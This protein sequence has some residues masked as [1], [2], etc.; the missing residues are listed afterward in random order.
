MKGAL[1]LLEFLNVSEFIAMHDAQEKLK[2]WQHHY[3]HAPPPQGSLDHL[4]PIEF[5]KNGRSTTGN[6]PNSSFEVTGY[7][8]DAKMA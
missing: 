4:T 1:A 5:V 8:E 3:N 7:G 6:S 2:A